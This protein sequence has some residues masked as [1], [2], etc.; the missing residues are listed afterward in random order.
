[1][2]QLTIADAIAAGQ[3]GMHQAEDAAGYGFSDEAE[4]FIR[5]YAEASARPFSSEAV[6][7][8]A[9]ACGLIPPDDR[10]W[11]GA[12]QRAARAG[13]IRRSSETYR[14]TRGHGTIGVKWEKM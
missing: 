1:M 7:A 5:R 12:F 4:R 2:H 6:V 10:A 14:R 13:V 11:G 8:A 9:R 3:R